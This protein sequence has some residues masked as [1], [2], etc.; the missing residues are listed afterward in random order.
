MTTF[1]A[2]RAN[3]G[4]QLANTLREAPER[5]SE[6]LDMLDKAALR[7]LGGAGFDRQKMAHC[8]QPARAEADGC[9]W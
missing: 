3:G 9:K 7:G 2:Y 8:S 6:M 1:K 5:K 4:Y